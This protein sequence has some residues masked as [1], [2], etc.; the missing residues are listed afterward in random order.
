M[1]STEDICFA[2]DWLESNDCPVESE[3]LGRVA[4]M[5]RSTIRQRKR[6]QVRRLVVQYAD[7]TDPNIKHTRE[8]KARIKRAVDA[9]VQDIEAQEQS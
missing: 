2:I 3:R 4:D 1:T 9:A 7:S 5:L 6:A 8:G